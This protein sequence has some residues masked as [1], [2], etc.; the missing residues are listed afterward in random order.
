MR[1]AVQN[2]SDLRERKVHHRKHL[3]QNFPIALLGA[4]HQRLHKCVVGQLCLQRGVLGSQTGTR[5]WHTWHNWQRRRSAYAGSMQCYQQAQQPQCNPGR[6]THANLVPGGHNQYPSRRANHS[7]SLS[8]VGR[9]A[10]WAASTSL[11][12]LRSS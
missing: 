6:K 2:L 3:A 5:C 10:H 12:N 9:S 1:R 11:D 8:E 4:H 7:F